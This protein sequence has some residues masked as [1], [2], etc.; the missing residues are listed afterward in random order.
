MYNA[1]SYAKKP[2]FADKIVAA[3]GKAWCPMRGVDCKGIGGNIFLFTFHQPSGR[4]HVDEFFCKRIGGWEIGNLS[5]GGRV[6]NVKPCLTNI[7]IYHI[8]T[9]RFSKTIAGRI[10][11]YIKRYTFWRYKKTKGNMIFLDGQ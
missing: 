7:P 1:Q 8:P 2:A 5:F 3:L 6:Q 11:K 4:V 10:E 9:Y